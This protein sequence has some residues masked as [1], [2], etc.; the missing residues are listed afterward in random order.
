MAFKAAKLLRNTIFKIIKSKVVWHKQP[1][2][3][4]AVLKQAVLTTNNIQNRHFLENYA[5]K[6]E[7]QSLIQ[8][9]TKHLC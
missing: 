6:T 4:E 1:I 7:K 2:F 8:S 5:E 3:K 9:I